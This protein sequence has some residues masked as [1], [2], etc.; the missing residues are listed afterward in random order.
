M[1][2]SNRGHW[3]MDI[4]ETYMSLLSLHLLYRLYDV[5]SFVPSTLSLYRVLLSYQKRFW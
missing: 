5:D 2:A 3:D 1:A 4:I